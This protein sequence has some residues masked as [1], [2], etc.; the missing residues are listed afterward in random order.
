[1]SALNEFHSCAG[2]RTNLQKSQMV[3]GGTYPDLQQQCLQTV[4]LRESSFPLHYLGVPI[5]ANKLTKLECVHLVDKFTAKVHQWAPRNI[6]YAG[7]LVLINSVLFGMF[8]YWAL[9]FLLPNKVIEKL[10]QISRNCLWSGTEDFKRPPHIS[11][12]HSC[13]PKSKGGLGIKEFAVWNRA[14]IAKLI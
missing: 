2:L 3:F 11:W 13:L 10:T 1:M 6:S 5:V 8:N 4:G 7:R 14:T 9:I 12:Q